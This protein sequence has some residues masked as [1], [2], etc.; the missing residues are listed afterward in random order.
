MVFRPRRMAGGFSRGV[1]FSG[2]VRKSSVGS[3]GNGTNFGG[4]TSVGNNSVSSNSSSCGQVASVPV[5]SQSEKT[6]GGASTGLPQRKK[7]GFYDAL[8]GQRRQQLAKKQITTERESFID[9][10][11]NL[12]Y[13]IVDDGANDIKYKRKG[14]RRGEMQISSGLVDN[15][16]D[17]NRKMIAKK[18]KALSQRGEFK[19]QFGRI[20][21]KD[22][23][24][25]ARNISERKIS[26]IGRRAR[27]NSKIFSKGTLSDFLSE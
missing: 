23:A 20:Q 12:K 26:K 6:G 5:F 7:W 3:V 8:V 11:K 24:V 21:N 14:Y 1:K 22:E 16:G 15:A 17:R 27:R 19:R 2:G 10:V 9:N 18:I 25:L 13:T 4:Q